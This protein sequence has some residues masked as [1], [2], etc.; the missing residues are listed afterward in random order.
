MDYQN[1]YRH[2]DTWDGRWFASAP[3]KPWQTALL[4]FLGLIVYYLAVVAFLESPLAETFYHNAFPFWYEL[5]TVILVSLIIA[6]TYG[7][8]VYLRRGGLADVIDLETHL[9]SP[10]TADDTSDIVRRLA[11]RTRLAYA[12][13]IAVGLVY[14]FVFTGS[15]AIF[16]QEQWIEPFFLFSLVS[17]PLA[18]GRAGW[19]IARGDTTLTLFCSAY[20]SNFHADVFDRNAYRPFVRFGMRAAL[21]W[22]ILFAIL[23]IL[24][25]DEGNNRT[26]FGELPMV[27][28]L[29]TFAILV[30]TYEFVVPL[31]KARRFIVREKQTETDWVIRDVKIER[32]KL[33]APAI[34]AE[35]NKL[36][37]L[38]AY[39]RELD[40]MSD[41]PVD[42]PDIGR[43]IVYLLIPVLSW[44]GGAGAQ[45]MIEGLIQ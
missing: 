7:S 28:L 40:A 18:F 43:F 14:V 13:G 37:D 6:Y 16:L 42:S 34:A 15:G 39:K 19:S 12:I 25:L 8:E 20:G 45:I 5:D 4:L 9:P 1:A 17:F 22:L 29:V 30:A 31:L 3:F 27:L 21:R 10:K 24:M 41:W 2:I 33:R 11:R 26:V 35:P 36:P 44:F 38:L 32:E 23:T